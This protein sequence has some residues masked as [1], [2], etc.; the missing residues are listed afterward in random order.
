MANQF[1]SMPIPSCSEGRR[2]PS[3]PLGGERWTLRLS[4]DERG[5]GVRQRRVVPTP[6]R[7]RPCT[8]ETSDFPGRDGGKSAVLRGEHVISRKAI[9]QG[10]PGVLRWTCMLVC[11]LF[12]ARRTRDRGCSAHPVFPA[13]SIWRGQGSFWQSSGATRR[14]NNFRRPGLE[15]G[16]IRRGPSVRALTLATFFKQH[17]RGV[18]VPAFAGTT[19]GESL[20]YLKTPCTRHRS[21]RNPPYDT[22]TPGS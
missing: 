9:A 7:W 20:T 3:R 10:R 15:P 12:S 13:P 16:P 5:R 8:W 1:I 18:W 4:L 11:T 2:P 6:R 22:T 19:S 17:R 14:E 21:Q